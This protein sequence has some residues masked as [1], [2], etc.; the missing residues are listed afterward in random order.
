MFFLGSKLIFLFFLKQLWKNFVHQTSTGTTTPALPWTL[1]G[2]LLVPSLLSKLWDYLE[3]PKILLI[4]YFE[5][6][7]VVL[8]LVK[9][10][11]ILKIV[12]YMFKVNIL[13]N[14][15]FTIRYNF[16][17]HSLYRYVF[18]IHNIDFHIYRPYWFFQVWS[19]GNKTVS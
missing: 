19:T 10:K 14:I 12:E 7:F 2:L 13:L 16:Q 9:G 5:K 8:F 17:M 3:N 18:M 4:T 15:L 1:L 11:L 6:D